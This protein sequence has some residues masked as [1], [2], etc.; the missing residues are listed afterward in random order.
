MR[1]IQR[2]RKTL[3]MILRYRGYHGCPSM[4]RI[5]V[6]EVEGDPTVSPV[7]IATELDSN[8]GTSV[9]NRI[10]VIAT[11]VYRLLERPEAGL[12]VIEHYARN[13]IAPERFALVTVVCEKGKS[14]ITPRWRHLT[15]GEIF[16]LVG[17]KL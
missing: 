11:E 17:N 4:C 1:P 5:R 10:E 12:T 14:F 6:Y 3:D 16:D 2:R 8:P 13:T 15:P 7:L 9:T